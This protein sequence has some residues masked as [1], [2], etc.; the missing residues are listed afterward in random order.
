MSDI[1]GLP[2]QPSGP[3]GWELTDERA[4]PLQ[5]LDVEAR[6]ALGNGLIGMRAARDIGRPAV[7]ATAT[8]SLAKLSWP[9]SYIA[10]LFDALDSMPSVK[11]MMA[12]PDWTRLVLRRD[13]APVYGQSRRRIDLRRSLLIAE[14]ETNGLALVSR[15]LVS[16]ADRAQALQ[17]LRIE[18]RE[19]CDLELDA[20]FDQTLCGLQPVHL[21]QAIG[22]WRSVGTGQALAVAAS[23]KLYAGEEEIAPTRRDVLIWNWRWRAGAGQSFDFVRHVGF[24][25][26]EPEAARAAAKKAL[27]RAS[28]GWRAVLD[29]HADAWAARWEASEI[30]IEGDDEAQQALRF[31]VH[32]LIAVANPDDPSVSI[33]A[34]GLSGD[35][36]LGHVFWDT[37]LYMLPFYTHT[38]PEAAR[39][40]LLYRHRSLD[41]A[42][43][44][45]AS[46]GYKG[47]MFAWESADTGD[48]ET[49]D[50]VLDEHGLPAEVLSGK[51]EHHI[52]AD[53]ANAVWS[54]WL[55]S[56]DDGFMREAGM[57]ILAET[58]RFW[59]SRIE[60]DN[61]GRGHINRV[62]GPD[63][64]HEAVDDSAFTNAMAARNLRLAAEAAARFPGF[65]VS[66]AECDAWRDLAGRVVA[67]QDAASGIFDQHKGFLAAPP[68][69]K[70]G[71]FDIKQADVVALLAVLPDLLP[72]EQ[73]AANFDLYAPRT[74][75]ASSLS[76]PMH[77]LVAARLGRT[78]AALAY[79]REAAR[80]DLDGPPGSDAAGLHMAA[81]GGLWQ[82][83]AMGFGG[84]RW[85]AEGLSV[86]PHLP[87]AWQEISFRVD[88]RG[89]SFALR[90]RQDMLHLELRDG[91][92]ISVDIQGRTHLLAVASPLAV[93]NVGRAG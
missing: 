76:R 30:R 53:I 37:E 67:G 8:P 68:D 40:L 38:W 35:G 74:S 70:H 16:L 66:A 86:S 24:A 57:E 59:A 62:I 49:P 85:T 19:D 73:I 50:H 89:R 69:T 20:W 44:K 18:A 77:A 6:M 22:V 31:A 65:G 83:A 82:V 21:G 13:G 25:R 54:F 52:T 34:R 17:L 92:P 2:L 4:S 29:A 79:F 36:Y 91:E 27:C 56:G 41:G 9:R 5:A 7:F 90:L 87:A 47:A 46:L 84:V 75:H 43:R 48:E 78:E 64:Y 72:A 80:L 15:R 10:G 28:V 81:I 60:L 88:G 12:A 63:E 61:A 58:A 32:H 51:Q 45:A 11:T 1:A 26:D 23:G 55:A 71:A 33:G 14:L 93:P 39:S 42:R 3:S